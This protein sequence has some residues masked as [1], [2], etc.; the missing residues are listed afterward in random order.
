[1]LRGI[2]KTLHQI[3]NVFTYQKQNC[4]IG[5]SIESIQGDISVE[6]IYTLPVKAMFK[7]IQKN[8]K[9]LVQTNMKIGYCMTKIDKDF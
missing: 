6:H 5:L 7:F 8:Y 3:F 4:Y 1:M 2:S 9:Y